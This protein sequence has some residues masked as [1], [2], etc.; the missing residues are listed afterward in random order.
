MSNLSIILKYHDNNVY[1]LARHKTVN[2]ND[3]ML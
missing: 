2:H 3:V 1:C